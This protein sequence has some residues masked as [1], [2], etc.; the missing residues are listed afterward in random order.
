MHSTGIDLASFARHSDPFEPTRHEMPPFRLFPREERFFGMFRDAAANVAVTADALL[1]L[2]VDYTN[3][4]TKVARIKDLEHTG[5]RLTHEI[6]DALSR[7]FVTPFDREDIARLANA[8]DDVVDYTEE[9]ARR[10]FTY[11]IEAPTALA[12]KFARIIVEQGRII[13]QAVPLLDGLAQD[14]RLQRYTVELHRL[15]DEADRLMDEAL[16]TLYDG[17]TDVPGNILAEKWNDIYRVLE[18]ATDRAEDVAA[19]L[20]TIAVKHG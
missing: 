16:A 1:D 15:E 10:F 7:A 4:E 8:L 18:G 6:S 5:D 14:E 9:A 13:A 20:G 12:E 3:V 19:A 2:I 11:R 17:V